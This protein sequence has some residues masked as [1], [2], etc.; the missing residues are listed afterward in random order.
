[1]RRARTGHDPLLLPYPNPQRAEIAVRKQLHALERHRLHILGTRRKQIVHIPA[2]DIRISAEQCHRVPHTG[3]PRLHAVLL[4]FLHGYRRRGADRAGRLLLPHKKPHGL[5]VRPIAAQQPVPPKLPDIPRH[6]NRPTGSLHLLGSRLPVKPI[7]LGIRRIKF[8]HQRVHFLRIEPGKGN[9]KGGSVYIRQHLGQLP[10]IPVALY[11]VQRHVQRLLPLRL[12][13]HYHA[14]DLGNAHI[15]Q[16]FQPL[17]AAHDKA[18][19]L[20]PDHRLHKT[21]LLN[22][23]FQFLI[24]L[25]PRLQVPPWVVRR[26]VQPPGIHLPNLHPKPPPGF[27]RIPGRR[28]PPRPYHIS[29]H[30]P[31]SIPIRPPGTAHPPTSPGTASPPPGS[32]PPRNPPA[33]C[34]VP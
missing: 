10:L 21:K 29:F 24:I 6:G 2:H 25:I 11:P 14:V 34:T 31:G 9:V 33:H 22:R 19:A 16:H 30:I 4:I 1:M 26:R 15:Q 8:V 23:A 32:I 13:I 3:N 5:R 17:V 18:G 28:I 7:L 12:H 27:T 20:I